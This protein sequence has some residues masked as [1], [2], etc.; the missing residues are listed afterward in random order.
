MPER[1]LSVLRRH[2][3]VAFFL[4]TFA[5]SWGYSALLYWVG[6]PRPSLVARIPFPWGPLVA[7]GVV[8]WAIGGDLREWAGQVTEWRAKPRWYLLAF[9]TPVVLEDV[10]PSALHV[11]AGGSVR[12]L[13]TSPALYVVSFVAV[14][15]LA[16]GLEEFG[17]RG[18]AQPRLQERHSALAAVLVIG[19]AHALWH[20]PLFLLFDLDAYD[21]TRF[22]HPYVFALVVDAAVLA[23]LYNSTGGGLLFAMIAH[24]AGNLPAVVAPRGETASI[25]TYGYEAGA[26]LLVGGLVVVHGTRYLAAER[27][28]PRIPGRPSRDGTSPL[29]DSR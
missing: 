27:P 13:P 23:W 18:F 8:T 11:L 25:A 4:L 22:V 2:P 26:I 29:G 1:R 16:G 9:A 28:T 7:A 21:A 12:F 5:W 19:V 10:I 20:L 3:V 17:W 24:S 6:G 14:L 15:V